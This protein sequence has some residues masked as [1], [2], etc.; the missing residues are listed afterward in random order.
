M[1][2]VTGVKPRTEGRT[3]T[4]KYQG[5]QAFKIGKTNYVFPHTYVLLPTASFEDIDWVSGDQRARRLGGL[6]IIE[7]E[8]VGAARDWFFIKAKVTHF[9]WRGF[10]SRP[11]DWDEQKTLA[12]PRAHY[13][14]TPFSKVIYYLKTYKG[15][16]IWLSL[17]PSWGDI[18]ASLKK[19]WE[20]NVI[21]PNPAWKLHIVEL[22]G[23]L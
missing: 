23:D 21:K 18:T 8:G 17:S 13:L 19:R 20:P 4:F 11:N 2:I 15:K 16:R 12:I 7:L 14:F 6:E 3:E 9:R 22:E 1:V 5:E 10:T